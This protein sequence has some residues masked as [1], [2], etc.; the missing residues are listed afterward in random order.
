MPALLTSAATG[1]RSR[2]TADTAASTW[3]LLV[4]SQPSPMT[5]PPL[6]SATSAAVSR[7]APSSRSSAATLHPAA[8]SRRMASRPMPRGDPAPVTIAVRSRDMSTPLLAR[9]CVAC[10]VSQASLAA[11]QATGCHRRPAALAAWRRAARTRWCAQDAHLRG[12]SR[13]CQHSKGPSS[14]YQQPNVD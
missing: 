1:G 14:N 7:A 10:P 2:S 13:T 4:T 8:A 9:D 3:S 11:R 6:A 5:C 12:R